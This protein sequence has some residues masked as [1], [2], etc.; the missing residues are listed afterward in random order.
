MT[1][2]YPHLSCTHIYPP[3]PVVCTF[4]VPALWS[5]A[6]GKVLMYLLACDLAAVTAVTIEVCEVIV[7]R[8][9]QHPRKHCNMK[10]WI[11]YV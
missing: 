6:C 11:D 7:I 5:V 2:I 9:H 3:A 4:M 10:L 8:I 1:H